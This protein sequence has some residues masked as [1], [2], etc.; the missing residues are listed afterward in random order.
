MNLSEANYH[1]TQSSNFLVSELAFLIDEWKP[2]EPPPTIL[3]AAF[4]RRIAMGADELSEQEKKIVFNAIEE[5]FTNG[6]EVVKSAISTGLLEALLN[7]SS[8]GRLSFQSIASYLGDM[9]R[10]YCQEWDRF[11]GC[12]TPGLEQP[13]NP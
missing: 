6:D 10:Q 13:N 2:D 11:T 12:S 8:S 9:S 4:G 7:E 5:C 3:Y 1:I